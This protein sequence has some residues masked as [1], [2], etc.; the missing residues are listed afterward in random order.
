MKELLIA[1]AGIAFGA[2]YAE[3]VREIAPILDPS[4][5]E[6]PATEA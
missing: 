5:D 1:V 4:K 6:A 2:H 3:K